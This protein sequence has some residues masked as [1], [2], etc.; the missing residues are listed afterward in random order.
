MTQKINLQ[1]N[2]FLH[3]MTTMQCYV[4]ATCRSQCDMWFYN[5]LASEICLQ[6]CFVN[7][8]TFL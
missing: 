6:S 8:D 3:L 1:C 7:K 4:L 2:V 5:K